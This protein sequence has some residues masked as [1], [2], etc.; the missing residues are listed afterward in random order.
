MERKNTSLNMFTLKGMKMIKTRNLKLR[1]C[2]NCNCGKPKARRKE[3]DYYGGATVIVCGQCGNLVYDTHPVK[4]KN[5]WNSNNKP[6]V[7][8]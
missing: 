1:K 4:T 2:L 3:R 8:G 5:K 6:I 7:K